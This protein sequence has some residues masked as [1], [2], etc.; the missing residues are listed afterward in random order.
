MKKYFI[1]MGDVIDS[2]KIDSEQLWN[3]INEV[4]D[5]ARDKYSS[6]IISSLEIK[7]GDELKSF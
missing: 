7:V 4:I 5:K 1:L 3:N 6:K 2:R